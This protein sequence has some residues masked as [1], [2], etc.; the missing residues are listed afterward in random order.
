MIPIWRGGTLSLIARLGFRVRLFSFLPVP[1]TSCPPK[2]TERIIPYYVWIATNFAASAHPLS[3][4]ISHFDARYA[5]ASSPNA[6]R[7]ALS[8]FARDALCD[9]CGQQL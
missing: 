7:P 6:R 4:L 1:N 3:R 5:S 8:P 2:L 9:V